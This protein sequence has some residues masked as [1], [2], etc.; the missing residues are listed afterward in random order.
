M[1]QLHVQ[2]GGGDQAVLVASEQ[3]LQPG[4]PIEDDHTVKGLREGHAEV[5]QQL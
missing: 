5:S 2:G 1:G 4:C 3:L